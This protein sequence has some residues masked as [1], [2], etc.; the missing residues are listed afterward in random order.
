M[1]GAWT[2]DALWVLGEGGPQRFGDLQAS[3]DGV[4]SKVL[5]E[6]LKS[7]LDSRIIWRK[8]IGGVPPVV[9]YGL[10]EEGVE[11]HKGL[12]QLAEIADKLLS[13]DET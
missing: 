1:G 12:K 11:L 10:T 9:T 3:L 4:S 13:P 8:H 7:M 2:L 5:T 6:R